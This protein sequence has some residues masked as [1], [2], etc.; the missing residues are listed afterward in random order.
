MSSI[1]NYYSGAVYTKTGVPSNPINNLKDFTQIYVV[2]TSDLFYLQEKKIR[3]LSEAITLGYLNNSAY[4]LNTFIYNHFLT[5]T[6]PIVVMNILDL[7]NSDLFSEIT[8]TVN[9]TGKNKAG[10]DF[11]NQPVNV[12][13]TT[14]TVLDGVNTLVFGTDYTFDDKKLLRIIKTPFSSTSVSVTYNIVNKTAMEDVFIDLFTGVLTG[15]DISDSENFYKSG[16]FII[17]VFN[18]NKN[19]YP[20]FLNKLSQNQ[21]RTS[22]CDTSLTT[23][24][25][26]D[27]IDSEENASIYGSLNTS[28]S[29]LITSGGIFTVKSFNNIPAEYD[30]ASFQIS[31]YSSKGL[32]FIESIKDVPIP[33]YV[34]ISNI[35]EYRSM[36]FENDGVIPEQ[37]IGNRLMGKGVNIVIKNNGQYVCLGNFTSLR[38][39]DTSLGGYHSYI[40]ILDYSAYIIASTLVKYLQTAPVNGDLSDMVELINAD[41]SAQLESNMQNLYAS[42][43]GKLQYTFRLDASAFF[44]VSSSTLAFTRLPF[45]FDFVPNQQIEAINLSVETS[46]ELLLNVL[47]NVI[48]TING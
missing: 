15:S 10:I 28:R 27:E 1:N 19:L 31:A 26:E 8:Q 38:K 37:K 6:A 47:N 7:A 43:E 17:P 40:Q 33:N 35:N 39:T 3:S 41:V 32:N 48:T 12:S 45:N 9:I 25:I 36:Y 22:A 5:S 13:S 23:S 24:D 46:R 2:G 14:F 20:Y 44:S 21:L 29:D 42:I 30:F 34:S 11:T 18:N 16:Y 4:T